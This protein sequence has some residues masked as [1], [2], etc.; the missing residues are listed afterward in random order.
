MHQDSA[1]MLEQMSHFR[2]QFEL[3]WIIGY[4]WAL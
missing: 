4:W 1:I 3:F 2:T